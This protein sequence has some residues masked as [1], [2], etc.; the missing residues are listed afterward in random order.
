MSKLFLAGDIRDGETVT[1]GVEPAPTFGAETP[2]P[3]NPDTIT[4]RNMTQYRIVVS[5]GSGDGSPARVAS[6]GAAHSTSDAHTAIAS[7]GHAGD[8]D[9]T[10]SDGYSSDGPEPMP[11]R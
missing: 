5:A 7:G 1:V 11:S 9:S 4:P 10:D 2:A 8:H 3:A 6:G